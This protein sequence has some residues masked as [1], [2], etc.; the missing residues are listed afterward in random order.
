MTITAGVRRIAA[1]RIP[2]YIGSLTALLLGALVV[3]AVIVAYE[4]TANQNRIAEATQR[5][6]RLQIAAQAERNFGSMR[7]WLTELAVSLLTLSE[8]RAEAARDDLKASL[9]ELRG[10]APATAERISAAV[11]GYWDKSIAA[12]DAYTDGNRVIG[13]TMMAQT[14]QQSA[15]VTEEFAALVGALAQEADAANATAAEA[16]RIA[17]R[18]ALLVCAAIVALGALSTLWVL[19]HI[20]GP[21]KQIDAG[22][23]EIQEGRP[24]QDLPPEGPDEF[25]RLSRTL[26]DLHETQQMRRTLEA[27]AAEQRRTVLTAIETIPDGFALYD[28]SDRLVLRNQRFLDMF[29][30]AAELADGATFADFLDATIA[31]GGIDFGGRTAEAW[32]AMRLARHADPRGTREEMPYRGGWMLVTQRR[33][34]DGGTVCVYSDITELRQRQTDLDIARQQAETANDSK[35]RFLASMSHE[36]RTPLNAIIGYSEMLIEDAA[37]AGDTSTVADL[38]KIMASGRHLLALINDIL[39]LSKIEAGKMELHI[40]R[41]DVAALVREVEATVVPLIAQNDN[42][43]SVTLSE[44]LGELDT[45]RTKLRQNL[46]NLLSNAAKFTTHGRIALDVRPEDGFVRFEVR[47]DGIGM[48]EEQLSR[49]FKPFSQAETATASVYGGT[50]L[51]L[52]IVRSFTELMGGS[53]SV[54]SEPGKGSAFTLRLPAICA[55]ETAVPAGDDAFGVLII[56]DDPKAL[57]SMSSFVRARGYRVWTADDAQTG[58]D[59]A[60][61][62]RPDVILLDVIMPRRDGWSVLRELKQDPVLCETPVILVSVV[63]DQ[64]LG[65]A[66]GAVDHIVKPVDPDHL[67]GRINRLV[68]DRSREVLIVDDDPATR[69]L[70]RRLLAREGWAVREAADGARALALIGEHPPGLVVLD[71]MMPNI[72]GFEVLRRLRDSSDCAGIPVIVATSKDL[73]RREIEWL[74]AHARDVIQK[75]EDGR[76]LLLAAIQRHVGRAAAAAQGD[77]T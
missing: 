60:R 25:G 5:F 21:L 49:L 35:S 47:D 40:E 55:A 56:D 34:P 22:M 68:G 30:A 12:V 64:D 14:R 8:R 27:A 46:F 63:N 44:G 50:G 76:A 39:D 77:R 67:L 31:S 51:G 73:S 4:F 62:E 74:G 37:D 18:R 3:S 23:S 53:V 45:D 24:P 17:R 11:D 33:T 2:R 72:D 65:L 32:K 71:L 28:E 19:R 13:N 1:N 10:F 42:H 52:S 15:A 16:S 7:Y 58:L 75:G 48:T 36:L 61:A 41:V 26:R 38:E 66:F 57:S 43:L 70:F 69:A 59:L 20:L 54:A 6:H 9:A 29:P